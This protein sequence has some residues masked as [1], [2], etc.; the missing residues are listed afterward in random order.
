MNSPSDLRTAT[1]PSECALAVALPLTFEAFCADVD[2]GATMDYSHGMLLGRSH[3]RAWS[4]SAAPVAAACAA[5]VEFARQV[6]I[7]VVPEARLPDIASLFTRFPVVTVVAHWRGA[8]LQGSDV[9]V[10][11]SALLDRFRVGTDELSRNLAARLGERVSAKADAAL[12]RSALAE[13]LNRSVIS[14]P[15]PL[16][17]CVPIDATVTF[18]ADDLWLES[19]HRRRIDEAF[20]DGIRRGNRLELRDG[21]HSAEAIAKCVP[22][23]WSGIIDLVNCHSAY[24]AETVKDRRPQRRVIRASRP[25]DPRVRLRI[26]KYLY[27]SISRGDGNY[28]ALLAAIFRSLADVRPRATGAVGRLMEVVRQWIQQ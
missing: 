26:Q 27:R 19:E 1:S 18:L 20:P 22:A 10:E 14:S 8:F 15:E 24:L 21:L 12:E 25:I 13:W 7:E 23:R 11:A 3:E 16:P 5:L 2:A 28:A 4:E 6:G 9:L 17:G